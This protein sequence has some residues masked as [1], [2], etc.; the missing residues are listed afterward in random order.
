[1]RV[2]DLV[3]IDLIAAVKEKLERACGVLVGQPSPHRVAFA[4]VSPPI[5]GLLAVA[6]HEGDAKVTVERS[7][8]SIASAVDL[9]GQVR[10]RRDI[11]GVPQNAPAVAFENGGRSD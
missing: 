1:M 7:V 10:G 9:V 3:G 5:A 11:E 4:A 2:E 8:Q 6:R